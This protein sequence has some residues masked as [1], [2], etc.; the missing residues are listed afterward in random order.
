MSGPPAHRSSAKPILS[1]EKVA[2]VR[3]I[4]ALDPLVNNPDCLA[5]HFLGIKHRILVW[6]LSRSFG[7]GRRL[8][9]K[10]GPGVYWYLQARTKHIDHSIEQGLADGIRQVVILGA[11]YDTR[12]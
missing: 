3:A 7:V 8:L 1:A 4:G 11:G 9:E 10:K 12:A 6:A 5:R 2:A